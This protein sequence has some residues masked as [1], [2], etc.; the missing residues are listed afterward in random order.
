[1][2][3]PLQSEEV[4]ENVQNA[5]FDE[6]MFVNPFAPPSTCLAEASSQKHKTLTLKWL[7]KN[8]LDEENM[9]IRNKTRLVIRGYC[10]EE[11]IDFKESFT[12][13]A[14]MEAIKILLAYVGHK[15]FIMFQMDVK[16]AFLHGSLKEDVYMCQHE[17]FIYVDHLIH[18]YKLKK[19][20]YGLKHE[21]RAWESLGKFTLCK[22]AIVAPQ[23]KRYSPV[24]TRIVKS[25]V[26]PVAPTT[27]EQKLARKN[28][29][30][31][32]GTTTKNLAFMSSSNTDSTTDLISAAAS[33]FAVCAKMPVPRLDNEDLKQID[34]DDLEEMDLRWH[35]AMLTMQ[36][37]R[38]LQNTGRNLKANGPTS[39]GFDMSKVECYNCHEKG[40]FARK[41][42]SPKDSKRTGAAE[43]HRRTVPVET[44]TSNALVS[45]FDGVGSYDWS[46]QAEEEPANFAL[47]AFLALSSSSDTEGVRK[48]DSYSG[49]GCQTQ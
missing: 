49:Q 33:V 32:C 25:V 34:V 23:G 44:S 22:D 38:F 17:G 18:V 28:E 7:F 11:G 2:K 5:T 35:M 48:V 40:H 19:V 14:K 24:P 37:R 47:M 10:Q 4:S 15:S 31:A 20:V 41:C 8:K 30:K 36:A 27:A 3:P 42:R 12:L 43:P 13:V 39:I 46:Y 26:Q 16:T 45:Q 29:L 6:D 9:I 21:P 1:K